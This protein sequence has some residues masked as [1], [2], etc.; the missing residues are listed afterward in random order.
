[1]GSPAGLN[2]KFSRETRLSWRVDLEGKSKQFEVFVVLLQT[3]DEIGF[4]LGVGVAGAEL[5]FCFCDVL[6]QD[7][8]G[9]GYNLDET[10]E[11]DGVVRVFF[12]F[13]PE[14]FRDL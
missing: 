2:L 1:L 5:F 11:S 9:A 10:A 4:A 3:L 12:A 6:K 14:L 13:E 7:T 8:L